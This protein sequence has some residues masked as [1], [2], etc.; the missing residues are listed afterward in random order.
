M[1][2]TLKSYQKIAIDNLVKIGKKLLEKEGSR[3]CVFKAPTGSGK[4]L[5]VADF[6]EQLAAEGL[7]SRYAFI[8]ISGNKLHEQSREKLEQYLNPTRYT[9]SYIEDVQNNEFKENEIVFVN[10]H[11]LTKQDRAT[12]EYTNVFMRDN[13]SDRNLRTF[14]A[15]TKEKGLQIILIVDESHYHYWSPKSQQLVQEV[16]GPKLTLEVSATPKLEPSADE[17][18]HED[19]G[20]VSVLFDDVIT[21]GMIKSE[22]I[23]NK[24]IGK[25]TDFGKAADDAILEAALEQ[26]KELKKQYAQGKVGVNPLVL[27]QLPSESESTSSL[28][29]TK[30]E[31]VENFLKEKHGITV[32]NGRLGIWLSER[33]DNVDGIEATDNDTEVLIFK[34]AIALGWD[35]P[36]AQILVMFRDI[37]SLTFEIQTVGRILRM[38]EAKHYGDGELDNAYVYTNLGKLQI[39][40]DR[41]SQSFFHLYPAHRRTGYQKIELPSIYLSRIDYGDLTLSFRSLFLEEAN[42]YFGIT[43]RDLPP[44]AKK[45]A[46]VKLELLPGKLTTPVISDTVIKDIDDPKSVIGPIVHFPVPEDDLKYKFEYFAKARSLPYAPVRSH[47][48][49]QQAIYDW[50]DNYLGYKD[51]SRIEIQRIVV[52][53]E[54]NQKIFKEIIETAKERFGEVSQKEKQAKQPEKNIVWEVPSIQYYN[55]LFKPVESS[56][57][58]QEPCYLQESRS[59]PE[60]EFEDEINKSKGI[61]WWYKNGTNKET[62]LA[63]SYKHPIKGTKQAFYPDYIISFKDGSIGIYD[64][65]SGITAESSETVAKSHALYEYL[66]ELKLKK[67]KATGGIVVSKPSGLFIYEGTKY[68]TD[69]DAP[70]WRRAEV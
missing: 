38:P 15:N 25:F 51:A 64:T 70:G 27:I 40:K 5:M 29:K 28:D 9:F 2:L 34:Q 21:E 58:A 31:F 36:R 65:K 46:D 14:I 50:F 35:C 37:K 3:V 24:E 32:E 42:K 41:E 12:G 48:K 60:R 55:E 53:S 62:F 16:I 61:S 68:T 43:E 49:I 4:T 23:I 19:A 10:W 54:S 69:H 13:E 66:Q 45:K 6:L 59:M 39:A 63:L 30:L 26:R 17:I 52:C 56:N 11:S 44:V 8:W 33:K 1:T 57:Y 22:V 18:A 47:T 7:P 20:Y 67:I